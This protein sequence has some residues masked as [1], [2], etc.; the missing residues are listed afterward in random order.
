MLEEGIYFAP[1]IFE[2]GFL[3]AAHT[4]EDI[5]FTIQAARRVLNKISD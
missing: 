1:S 4:D 5:D 3:S 2:A